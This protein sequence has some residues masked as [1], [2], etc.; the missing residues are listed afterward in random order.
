ML[1]DFVLRGILVQVDQSQ[2][3]SLFFEFKRL[4]NINKPID[5]D[6][7]HVRG[8][9]NHEFLLLFS[10][11]EGRGTCMESIKV[12]IYCSYSWTVSFC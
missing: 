11:N 4:M 2:I 6:L 12:R 8:D 1:S 3:E 7:P 5:Q 10:L 9:A